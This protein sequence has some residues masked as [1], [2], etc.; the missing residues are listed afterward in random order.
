MQNIA[1]GEV[2]DQK[3]TEVEVFLGATVP[4]N[5][6]EGCWERFVQTD[7][8]EFALRTPHGRRSDANFLILEGRGLSPD[9]SRTRPRPVPDRFPYPKG[10]DIYDALFIFWGEI[11]GFDIIMSRFFPFDFPGSHL[12]EFTRKRAQSLS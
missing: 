12:E 2:F 8:T 5:A 6:S 9:P 11:L 10:C 4:G 3:F 1:L 7:S